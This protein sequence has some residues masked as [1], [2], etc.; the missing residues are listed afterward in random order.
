MEDLFYNLTTRK[1]ALKNASEQY[2]RILDVVQKYAI[3]FGGKGVGFVCK[4]VRSV[5]YMLLSLARIDYDC[6]GIWWVFSTESRR[7]V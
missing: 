5:D 1:Q 7:A 2:S 3:H 4:K 6:C